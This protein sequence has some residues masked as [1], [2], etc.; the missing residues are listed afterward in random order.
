M[1]ADTRTHGTE[2]NL[3]QLAEWSGLVSGRDDSF[4]ALY[5]VV[6]TPLPQQTFNGPFRVTASDGRD[7]F[8]K[9]LQMCP[10][11]HEAS[12]AI[13]QV[14]AQVGQLIGAPVCESSLI[15]IP[16]AFA[17]WT[18][19]AGGPALDEGLAHAVERRSVR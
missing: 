16:A 18:P 4:Q 11:G 5:A 14:V 17:G 7:Y 6:L 1:C 8:V 19:Q 15:R 2:L 3:A 9:A 10:A 12:L 13:E